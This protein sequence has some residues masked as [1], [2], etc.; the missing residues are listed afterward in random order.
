[1]SA[2]GPA[3]PTV[4]PVPPTVIPV[5]LTVIPGLVPGIADRTGGGTPGTRAAIDPRDKPHRR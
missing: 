4:I 3:P 5:P 1:M 2:F